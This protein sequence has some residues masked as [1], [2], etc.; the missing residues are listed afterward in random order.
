MSNAKFKDM[1]CPQCDCMLYTI[2][3]GADGE[4][5]KAECNMCG[6][7]F[8]V[9]VPRVLTLN[10]AGLLADLIRGVQAGAKLRWYQFG[11]R[12]ADHPLIVTMRAFT[13]DG[14]GF[15]REDDDVRDAYVW[16]SGFMER[17]L[18]VSDIIT[19]LDNMDGKHGLEEP[20]AVIE[21]DER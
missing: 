18:K 19:A 6:A 15:I 2:A 16:C 7:A 11:T 13:Y 12:D 9:N 21:H 10:K 20:M 5:A 4:P 1:M 8:P 17:W 14:G 3:I